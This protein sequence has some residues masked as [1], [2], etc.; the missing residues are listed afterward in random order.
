MFFSKAIA[1]LVLTVSALALHTPR[2]DTEVD[3]LV[4]RGEPYFSGTQSGEA[5]YYN[6]GLGACG[7]MNTESDYVT[8][9]SVD[10]F[11]YYPGYNGGDFSDDLICNKQI[12]A[13]CMSSVLISFLVTPAAL[14]TWTPVRRHSSSWLICPS[15]AFP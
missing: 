12:T 9:V 11:D 8:T 2:A 6:V 15:A 5:T 14:R 13:S 3:S 10:L 4:E 1:A 7:I